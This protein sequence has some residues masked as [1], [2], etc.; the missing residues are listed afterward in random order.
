M[1][2]I[3]PR[4]VDHLWYPIVVTMSAGGTKIVEMQGREVNTWND[5]IYKTLWAFKL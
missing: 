5:G 4:Y 1:I 2:K 3:V